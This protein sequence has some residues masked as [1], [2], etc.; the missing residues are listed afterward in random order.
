MTK[1]SYKKLVKSRVIDFWETHLRAE[2]VKLRES[3]LKFF[4]AE[5]MSLSKPHPIWS[6]CG[7]NPYEVHKAVVQS[8]ML[9]GR[10]PTDKLSRHWT[11][12][13]KSG[14]C[15]I[16]GCT[17]NDVSSLDHILL[18]CPALSEARFRMTELCNKLASE[19]QDV[20]NIL[21]DAL[22][23][24]TTD[25]AMQ[26]L[27]DCSSLPAVVL[28]NQKSGA[29]TLERLFYLTHTWCYSIHRSRLIKLGLAQ[30]I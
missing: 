14:I 25:M 28:L 6:T 1:I 16:P 26:F 21:T 13:N 10:Y 5:F 3:A 17:G 19:N 29:Y 8:R 15:S 20:K 30:Y 18:F 11:S 2:A 9:S 24:Q 22:Q 4:K 12:N 23:N 27:L 7:S